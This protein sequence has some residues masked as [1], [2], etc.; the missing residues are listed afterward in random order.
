[1]GLREDHQG[2]RIMADEGSAGYYLACCETCGVVLGVYRGNEIDYDDEH[3]EPEPK[4]QEYIIN[5][6]GTFG[7]VRTVDG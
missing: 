5:E 7:G 4:P 2:H 6:D 3:V 1:M